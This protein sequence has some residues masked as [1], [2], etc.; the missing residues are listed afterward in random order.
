MKQTAVD[1]FYSRIKSHFEHDEIVLEAITFAKAI[2]QMKEVTQIVEAYDNK[3]YENGI[4][5]Y[6]ET[7]L[8]E[9]P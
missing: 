6:T 7:Y 9:K 8:K 1:W 3:E 5:Y 2:A 4:Q